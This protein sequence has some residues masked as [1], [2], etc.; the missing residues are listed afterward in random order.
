[1]TDH[2]RDNIMP[3]KMRM[4]D[5]CHRIMR[6][7]N[8]KIHMKKCK[9]LNQND[10]DE[11]EEDDTVAFDH[12]SS[13]KKRHPDGKVVVEIDFANNMGVCACGAQ[14]RR[15]LISQWNNGKKFH[16]LVKRAELAHLNLL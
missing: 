14:K 2:R 6:S 12:L 3:A 10:D 7:D 15:A 13:E 5:G 1:M 11:P 8:L 9:E 4:C 16:L